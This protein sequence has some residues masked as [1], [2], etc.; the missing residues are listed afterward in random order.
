[1][2]GLPEGWTIP[3]MVLFG[4]GFSLT[5]FIGYKGLDMLSRVAVPAMLALLVWSLWLATR[6]VGGLD[7]LLA[8]VPKE[9]MSMHM[10][11]TL[12]FGTFVSGATQ[13]TNWTRFARDG[14]TAVLSSLVG[15]FIG[16][17]LM[18]VVGAYGAMVYQQ[19]D[20]VEVMVLQ[21]L[22]IAAVVMLFL[23][24]WTTQDNT[25]YNFAAAGCNLLRKDRRGT[26]TLVG[27]GIGTLLAIGGM[28]NM[29]IP[30]L[31]LLG[32]IIPPIGGVIVADFF[33]GHKGRYPKLSTAALPRFNWVGLSAYAIGALCAYFSPWVAPLVG[34][35]VAALSYVLLFELQRMRITRQVTSPAQA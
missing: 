8:I 15:F 35:A 3:L 28:Y 2:L 24:I 32:S 14:K 12:V 26:I 1:M 6:D 27:A 22:S 25:I 16:N 11:I 33:Y 21:G 18:I 29:L 23:N 7:G 9:S 10:A 4:F 20:I 31:I 30:F 13:A 17:G 19:A 5:A 34:I